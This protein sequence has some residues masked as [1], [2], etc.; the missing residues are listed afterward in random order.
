MRQLRFDC[1]GRRRPFKLM[2]V[3]LKRT[4]DCNRVYTGT[5]FETYLVGIQ[6]VSV[7]WCGIFNHFQNSISKT[8]TVE[9]LEN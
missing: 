3:M 2:R 6:L 7:Y 9:I 8:L 1:R 4:F 5:K